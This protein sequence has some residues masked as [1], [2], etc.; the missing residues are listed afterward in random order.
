MKIIL[1][2]LT[3]AATA[4]SWTGV[5]TLPQTQDLDFHWTGIPAVILSL[6]ALVYLILKSVGEK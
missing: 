1:A 4:L 2:W 5:A 6:L 3:G